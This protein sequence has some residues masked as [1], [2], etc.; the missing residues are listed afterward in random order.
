MTFPQSPV[1]LGLGANL[2][3]RFGPPR[4]ALGAALLR[5]EAAGVRVIGRS[6]WYESAPV[7]ASD[8]PWYVNGVVT[9]AT[10]LAPDSLLALLLGV[11]AEMGR[12]RS[13]QN[14]ARMLDLDVVADGDIVRHPPEP[15][16]ELPHPRMHQ[17]A[18]V[19]RPLADLVPGWHHP[20]SGRAIEEL[21]LAL[22]DDQQ[23][24]TLADADGAFGT[25][26]R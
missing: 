15:A 21:L 16:P 2:A 12:E 20:E 14:A 17:R 1:I 13:V 24:R 25:E 19:V 22:P 4:A 18:F 7:P 6:P 26:W 10:D 3:S 9:V 8:Q 5:I 11:E 23:I